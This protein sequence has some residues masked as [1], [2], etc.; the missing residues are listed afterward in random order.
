MSNRGFTPRIVALGIQGHTAL[1]ISQ[2]VGCSE[3]YASGVMRAWKEQG[4]EIL[5]RQP[6]KPYQPRMD[7]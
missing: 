5:A 6:R 1:S 2:R 4:G 7:A 3:E